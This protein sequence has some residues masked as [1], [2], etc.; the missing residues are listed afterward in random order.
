MTTDLHSFS[1]E[2]EEVG[3]EREEERVVIGVFICRT[4]AMARTKKVWYLASMSM[5]QQKLETQRYVFH[6]IDGKSIISSLIFTFPNL[7]N[8]TTQSHNRV[9]PLTSLIPTRYIQPPHPSI[10]PITP[11]PLTSLPLI[12]T[13]PLLLNHNA[14]ITTRPTPPPPI[15]AQTTPVPPTRSLHPTRS[16]RIRIRKRNRRS[17][18]R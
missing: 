14:P 11:P 18:P 6:N 10:P 1:P 5:G 12:P 15:R 7:I 3:D 8:P 2:K 9:Y 16:R 13:P 17:D 4:R